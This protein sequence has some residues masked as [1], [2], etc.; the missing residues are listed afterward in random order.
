MTR[1]RLDQLEE[2]IAKLEALIAT[3]PPNHRSRRATPCLPIE[4]DI[5]AVLRIAPVRM[6]GPMIFE[7]LHADRKHL[8]VDL[9]YGYKVLRSMVHKGMI[10][11]DPKQN[12]YYSLGRPWVADFPETIQRL[13]KGFRGARAKMQGQAEP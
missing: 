6:T 13:S 4:R 12:G 8:S 2:R 11:R 1:S 5:E 3:S 10:G 9:E 7:A